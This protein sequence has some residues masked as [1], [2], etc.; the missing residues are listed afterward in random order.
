VTAKRPLQVNPGPLVVVPDAQREVWTKL[1]G[2]R[3]E[4][5]DGRGRCA[6]RET[7]SFWNEAG[8]Y[9]ESYCEPHARK[10]GLS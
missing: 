9:S 2:F 7:R 3:C 1:R 4:H 5:E 6:S 8:R 10:R